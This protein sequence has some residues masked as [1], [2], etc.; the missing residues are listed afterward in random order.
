MKDVLKYKGFIGSVHFNAEDKTFYGRIEGVS[1]LVTF[2]GNTVE[3]LE[4]AF[5]GAVEDYVMLC[6]RVKK[7][8][9]R[10]CKGSFNVRIPPEIHRKA[11]KQAALLGM[12]LN[13]FVQNAIEHEVSATNVQVRGSVLV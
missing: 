6:K 4:K 13:Q 8:P 1:D 10:S 12:S 2:E 7:E 3:E 9:L 5:H 11:V